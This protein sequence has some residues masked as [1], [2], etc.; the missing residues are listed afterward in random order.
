[1]QVATE[2]H[3][4]L[5]VVHVGEVDLQWAI[6]HH[7]TAYNAATCACLFIILIEDISVHMSMKAT[8][9]S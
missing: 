7:H 5:D 3:E 1:V 4:V 2:L 6:P 8:P 9:C